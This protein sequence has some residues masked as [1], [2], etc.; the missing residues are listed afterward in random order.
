MESTL[1]DG[2][3]VLASITVRRNFWKRFMFRNFPAWASAADRLLCLH[4]T[5][6]A[7]ER[8]W[9]AWGR[10]FTKLRSSLDLEAAHRMIYIKANLRIGSTGQDTVVHMNVLESESES[11]SD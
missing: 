11:E 4:A 8:N 3:V 6:C 10:T 2:K 9:S 5:S 7:A 1:V